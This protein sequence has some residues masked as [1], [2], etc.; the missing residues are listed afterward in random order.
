MAHGSKRRVADYLRHSAIADASSFR[1]LPMVPFG[2]P[3][4]GERD[5]A[6]S[7]RIAGAGPI[8]MGQH[9]KAA[10][11]P[12]P[13]N[14]FEPISQQPSSPISTPSLES[15]TVSRTH[16]INTRPA[17]NDASAESIRP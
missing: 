6:D 13:D 7:S 15:K 2:L 14:Q 17:S 4:A 11:D 9:S 10:S 1:P 5:S 8:G 3:D 16:L 12:T